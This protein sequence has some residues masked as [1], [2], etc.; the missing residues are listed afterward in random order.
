MSHREI[1]A[2]GIAAI[3]SEHPE[4]ISLMQLPSIMSP[5]KGLDVL[6]YDLTL[7][8]GAGDGHLSRLVERLGGRVIG[9][10]NVGSGMLAEQAGAAGVAGCLTLEST[11]AEVMTGLGR[12]A[13]GLPL[14]GLSRVGLL[15]ARERE[16]MTLVFEGLGNAE[17]AD[18]LAISTNT[19]KSH[20][21]TAYKKMGV[22]SRAQAV[23]WCALYG[24]AGHDA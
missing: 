7:A 18:R 5:V 24:V 21:R 17:I 15:S 4:R 2:R 3:L 19:L 13:A 20:I 12:A 1:V 16:I 22:R 14:P 8:Q 9:L 10:V 6:V 23:A 11:A